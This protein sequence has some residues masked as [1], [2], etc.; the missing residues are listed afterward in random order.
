MTDGF[1]KAE[2]ET[3]KIDYF[4][5]V[6]LFLKSNKNIY[7]EST[8]N[9]VNLPPSS[10]RCSRSALWSSANFDISGLK[11]SDWSALIKSTNGVSALKINSKTIISAQ[12]YTII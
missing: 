6:T 10:G 3:R 12:Q 1:I 2:S 5:F 4:R 11:L 8:K 9:H 7:I